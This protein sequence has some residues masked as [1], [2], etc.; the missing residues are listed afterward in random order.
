[1]TY[2]VTELR[3]EIMD[4]LRTQFKDPDWRLHE[5]DPRTTNDREKLAERVMVGGRVRS[6]HI[7]HI[8]PQTT[9]QPGQGNDRKAFVTFK[10]LRSVEDL[11]SYVE[12]EDA[13]DEFLSALQTINCLETAVVAGYGLTTVLG[14]D[15]HRATISAIFF[16]LSSP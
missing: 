13:C 8:L 3:V 4:A 11:E 14:F 15:C 6:F 5:S 10:G 12:I 9:P 1:M 16:A 7:Q 2:T